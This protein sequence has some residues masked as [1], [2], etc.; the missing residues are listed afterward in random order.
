MARMRPA[1]APAARPSW[2][3]WMQS[4]S[5]SSLESKGEAQRE[6]RRRTKG[7]ER[8]GRIA[9]RA[10][11]LRVHAA[12]PGPDGA[13]VPHGERRDDAAC[14]QEPIGPVL[15]G[16]KRERGLAEPYEIAFLED[17]GHRAAL[18]LAHHRRAR[19]LEQRRIR[20][21]QSRAIETARA[22]NALR[23]VVDEMS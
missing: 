8:R 4:W 15:I 3:S 17:P 14:A 20:V 22:P 10:E 13:Q 6:V 9:R 21:Q 23:V 2:S 5:A 12:E 16:S 11:G 1:R 19:L 18:M 7:L